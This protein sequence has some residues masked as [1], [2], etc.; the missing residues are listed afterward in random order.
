M[1]GLV[2]FCSLFAARPLLIDAIS[3]KVD[4]VIHYELI[5]PH[6]QMTIKDQAI[7]T[8][9]R[10]KKIMNLN[11]VPYGNTVATMLDN[12]TLPPQVN[13][14]CQHG[15][16]ECFGNLL[17]VIFIQSQELALFS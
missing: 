10:L 12:S 11:I 14:T 16:S 6:S 15:A 13:F 8:W 4:I 9:K 3:L 5:C 7:P 2:L 1:I 17:M